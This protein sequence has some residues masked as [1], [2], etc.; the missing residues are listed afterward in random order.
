MIIKF[1]SIL[2]TQIVITVDPDSTIALAKTK[3]YDTHGIDPGTCAFFKESTRLQNRATFSQYNICD[4]ETVAMSLYFGTHRRIWELRGVSEQP[5][6]D[7]Q[8]QRRYSQLVNS[9]LTA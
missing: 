2:G 8:F 1:R 5:L 4:G 9:A 7:Q 6:T 3:L